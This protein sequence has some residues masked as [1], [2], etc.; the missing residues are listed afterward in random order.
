MF[1]KIINKFLSI[2]RSTIES[3]SKEITK[4]DKALNAS[5]QE[6]DKLTDKKTELELQLK[7]KKEK[8]KMAETK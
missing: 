1:I 3:H 8:L 7:E 4:L 5:E 2:N 6:K